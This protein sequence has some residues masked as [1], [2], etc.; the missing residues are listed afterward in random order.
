MTDINSNNT[1][2]NNSNTKQILEK[3]Q[4]LESQGKYEEA[5]ALRKKLNSING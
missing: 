1:S 3:I 2:N 4:I 5:K